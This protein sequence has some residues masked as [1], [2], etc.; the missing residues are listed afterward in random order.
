MDQYWLRYEG[1]FRQDCREGFG[2]VYYSN[3]EKFSGC[4]RNDKA[5]GF[6]TFYRKEGPPLNGVW[7]QNRFNH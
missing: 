4:F 5:E 3:G 7:Q 2:S 6:G 1:E